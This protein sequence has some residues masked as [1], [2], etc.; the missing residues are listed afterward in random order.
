MQF[1]LHSW[2]LSSAGALSI[3]SAL[4]KHLTRLEFNVSANS[5][6]PIQ[7]LALLVDG[8]SPGNLAS[9]NQLLDYIH[10]TK[11]GFDGVW[12]YFLLQIE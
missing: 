11:S 10:L 6:I 8:Y 5:E 7:D 9:K 4:R 1:H 12:F 2:I 3:S